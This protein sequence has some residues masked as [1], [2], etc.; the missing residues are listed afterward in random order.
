MS[1]ESFRSVCILTFPP[2]ISSAADSSKHRTC[3]ANK[4]AV[5]VDSADR[6]WVQET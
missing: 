5:V 3:L 6:E 4:L 1:Q 2:A